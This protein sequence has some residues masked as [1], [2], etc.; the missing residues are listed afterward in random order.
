MAA[1]TAVS[2]GLTAFDQGDY[3]RALADWMPPAQAGDARAQYLVGGLF[4]DGN[5]VPPDPIHAYMWFAL[6]AEQGRSDAAQALSSLS[7]GLSAGQIAEA[8][9]LVA[10]RAKH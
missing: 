5:G 10:E 6:A 9:Q 7:A 4:R 8:K 2:S 1:G 3:Q